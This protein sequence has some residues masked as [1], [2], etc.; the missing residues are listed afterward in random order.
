[1][2][3]LAIGAHPDDLE[4]LCGG[5]LARFVREGHEVVMCHATNGDKGSYAH[6]AEEL[7]RIRTSEARHAAEICGATHV[8]LGLPDGDVIAA[9]PAQR[10]LFVDLVR[11][12]RPDLIITHSPDDYNSDHNETSKLTFDS[13]FRATVPL[14]VTNKPCHDKVTPIYFFDTLS[15]LSFVPT[16]FVDVSGVMAIKEAM[17]RC[18]ESQVSWTLEHD[19]VDLVEMMKTTSAFRGLQCGV[20]YAEA[21]A[22]CLTGLRCT[23]RRLLP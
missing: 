13:S 3:V 12:S 20:A 6:T 16:E 22:T 19:D 15:G 7:S 8:S 17:L 23:T 4:T 9:D 18:H 14:F 1:M 21:F 5:T 11:E 10:R 2:R